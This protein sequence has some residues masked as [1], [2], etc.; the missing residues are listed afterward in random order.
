MFLASAITWQ[1]IFSYTKVNRPRDSWNKIRTAVEWRG[2]FQG[3]G[4]R[5]SSPRD[6]GSPNLRMIGGNLNTMRFGGNWT[7][8]SSSENM[9]GFLGFKI[10]PS[11]FLINE[12]FA[13]TDAIERHI[14]IGILPKCRNSFLKWEITC[15]KS[16][17]F[18]Y[19]HRSESRWL[20][21][22]MHWFTMAR[23]KSPPFG[24]G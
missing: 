13:N 24:S 2:G 16:I 6:P 12:S 18:W 3:L 11:P 14:C 22:P 21:T 1:N 8:K 10:F 4:S 15:S 20:P 5:W 17:H 7:P 19:L 9:I 23:Y